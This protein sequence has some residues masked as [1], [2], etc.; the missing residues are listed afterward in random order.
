[1]KGEERR[2]LPL[3]GSVSPGWLLMK[4]PAPK[5]ALTGPAPERRGSETAWMMTPEKFVGEL[6]LGAQF[7]VKEPENWP[8][9]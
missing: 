5:P 4:K 9:R 7:G 3:S 1:M 8:V 2:T 6:D